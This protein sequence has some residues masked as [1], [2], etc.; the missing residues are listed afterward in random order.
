MCAVRVV[1]DA[2]YGGDMRK[3]KTDLLL[4]PAEQAELHRFVE[5]AGEKTA[6]GEL[7]IDRSTLAR[8]LGGLPV[9]RS[10]LTVLR[11]TLARRSAERDAR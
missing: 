1:L 9:R 8:A 4:S 10:T 5:E 2:P 3:A 6:V 11:L 7:K